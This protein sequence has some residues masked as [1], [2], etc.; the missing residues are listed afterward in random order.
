M[1][2]ET[3]GYPETH[4]SNLL[5]ANATLSLFELG[6]L[7]GAVCAGWGRI[8]YSV[9]SAPLMILLFSPRPV[10]CCQRPVV[11]T[12]SSLRTA[13]GVFLSVPAFCIPGPQMYCRTGGDR[14]L[15]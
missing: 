9:V 13:G 3:C 10:Y 14:I 12:D 5:S 2:G 7:L 11:N 1:T 8:F 6:G 4:G 15:P